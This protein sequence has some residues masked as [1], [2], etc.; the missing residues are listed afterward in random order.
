MNFEHLV[1]INDPVN[2]LVPHLSRA[3]LW[4]GLVLR[5]ERPQE[6]VIGLDECR[7]LERRPGFMRRELRFGH[8]LLKDTVRLMALERVIYDVEATEVS[9]PSQLCMAIEEPE[10]DRLFLRFTYSD[11]GSHPDTTLED[12]MAA[13]VR[14]AYEQADLDTVS[15]IRVWWREGALDAAI[16]AAQCNA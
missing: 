8:W 5:A 12:F 1:E 14:Q 6:V 2:P 16:K 13:H 11:Q 7:V 10:T 3:Q 9:P 4:A 15:A